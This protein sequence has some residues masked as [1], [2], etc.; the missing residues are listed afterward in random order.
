MRSSSYRPKASVKLSNGITAV[1]TMCDDDRLGM[2]VVLNPPVIL[3][4]VVLNPPESSRKIDLNP[5]VS[6]Y[7]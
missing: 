1:K 5:P 4:K 3:K 2:K 6:L 7:Y